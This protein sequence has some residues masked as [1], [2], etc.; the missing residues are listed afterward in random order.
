MRNVVVSQAQATSLKRYADDASG[1]EDAINS[2]LGSGLIEDTPYYSAL[3]ATVVLDRPTQEEIANSHEY[4][5][6]VA[7]VEGFAS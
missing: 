4:R 7:R 1:T 6:S 3:T 2:S 5:N